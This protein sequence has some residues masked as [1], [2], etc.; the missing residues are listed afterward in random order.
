MPVIRKA[1][2]A[3][4]YV[5]VPIILDY[6]GMTPQEKA[7]YLHYLIQSQQTETM[8][9]TEE[10]TGLSTRTISACR[11]ALAEKYYLIEVGDQTIT[12]LDVHIVSV[13]LSR[14][15]DEEDGDLELIKGR[16]LSRLK[17]VHEETE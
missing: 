7:L 1:P 12:L 14:I 9:A 5:I 8:P 3:K 11:K 6:L 13:E 15:I 16:L 10:F 2:S 17:E 4:P